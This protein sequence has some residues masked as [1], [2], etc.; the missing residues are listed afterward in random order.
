MLV[1]DIRYKIG[2]RSDGTSMYENFEFEGV[3]SSSTLYGKLITHSCRASDLMA[4]EQDSDSL[5]ERR[6]NVNMSSVKIETE[7]YK[8][9]N[10]K[11]KKKSVN[12]EFFCK[13]GALIR[14]AKSKCMK[15]YADGYTGL[16]LASGEF[17]A[18]SET[19]YTIPLDEG[20]I[21]GTVKL[22]LGEIMEMHLNTPDFIVDIYEDKGREMVVFSEIKNATP[23]GFKFDQETLGFYIAP[24]ITEK[25][26][27]KNGIYTSLE[28]IMK[29]NPD[30]EFDWLL[31]NK[32]KIVS[33]EDLQYV[34]DYIMSY[35]GYVYYD[36]ETT[37]LNITFKSRIGQAD[38]LVGVVLSVKYGESFYFPT[39]MKSIPNLCGGDHWY[40]MEHYMRPILEGKQLVAHNMSYDWKVSYIYD[41]NANIVHD[42]MA[43]FKLT[44]GAEKE[45][46]PMGLKELARQFL[47][48]DSLEL[49]DLIEADEWGESDIKFWDLPYESV[50]L[51]A[52]ADTDNTKGLL[53]YALSQEL[54]VKYNATR[55]YEIEIAFSFAVAYQEFYGHKV[56]VDNLE[57]LRSEITAGL[58]DN[59]NKLVD[60][61][62]Y[63]FNPNSPSQLVNIMYN[64]LGIPPQISRKTNRPTTDKETL[65]KLSEITD[66]EGNIKYPFC[67]I[68]QKYREFEGVRKILD[69]FPDLATEDGYLFSRVMQYGTTTGRVSIN[70][71]NYQSYN[72]PVKKHIVP[73][74][75]FYMTDSDYS[76]VEYRVLG[77]MSGNK[78]IMEG[79]VDPDFDYHA[80]QAARMYNVPYAAVTKTLRKAAKGINFGLPY[81]M[82]DESLG[83]RVFGE[84]SDENTRKAA[85]LR[86]KYFEGQE[87][88]QELFE[89]ARANGVNKGYTETYFGRRRYYHR[90][91]FSVNAIRRQAGNQVIQGCQDLNT[92]ILTKEF[93]IVKLGDILNTNVTVWDGDKWSNGDV[94]PAGNKRKTVIKFKG[95]QTMICS[96]NHKFLV[97]T[98]RGGTMWVEAQDLHTASTHRNPHRIVVNKCH[99]MSDYVYKSDR[100]Y[101]CYTSNANNI[102]LEDID[103]SYKIGIVLGRLASDGHQTLNHS[104]SNAIIQIVAEHEFNIL[105]KLRECMENLGYIE[106][107][108]DIR[109]DRNES[110]TNLSVYSTSL[111]K[112]VNDLDIRHK[113][114]KNIFMDTELLRGFLC[115]YFD[116]DGGI[117]GKTI[118][119]V[120]GKQDNFKTLVEDMQKAL[121]FFGIRSRI[122]EY[123]DRWILQIKTNDNELFLKEIGFLN[124]D[125]QLAGSK[126][127]CIEEEKTFGRCII[128]ESVE[129]TDELIPMADVCNTDGGYYVADG[130]VTHNTA[131]D[132]YKLAVGRLFKR[133][134]KEGWLGKV[135]L[136]GFIHDEVLCEVHN[137]IDPM[138]WLKVLREEFEVKIDGWCPLYMGFG[139]GMSWYEA[140]SVELPIKL[141]W[142]L[143][144]RYGEQGYPKWNGNG[145][146]LCAEVPDILR[147]FSIRDTA[148]QLLDE[149][150]QNNVIKPTLNNEM[151]DVL[152]EDKGYY[153]DV[154]NGW[155]TE[156]YQEAQGLSVQE[157][158]R[159]YKDDILNDLSM[160]HI[161]G[162]YMDGDN[163]CTSFDKTKDT[164]QAITDFCML[165]GVDRSKVNLLNIPDATESAVDSESTNVNYDYYDEDDES[166]FDKQ[167]AIDTRIDTLG[168]YLDVQEKMIM[169]KML[170]AEYMTF[171]KS[172]S[173]KGSGDYKIRF[174]DCSS[175]RWF[176]TDFY[177]MSEDINT[178][179]QL[180]IRYFNSLVAKR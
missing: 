40:F 143:V 85:A 160:C 175:M 37:G 154:I 66:I 166:V 142:E 15:K 134:C 108:H 71:P 90:N 98:K 162:L 25:V 2:L 12:Y 153:E 167:K 169:L 179:Q 29:N 147:D 100:K 89:T 81:G 111:S 30:R 79:F 9:N 75:G 124:I 95:G 4:G 155:L 97:A 119:C 31:D 50:R 74:P 110:I 28:D 156:S 148:S 126:L 34:C 60:I 105:P 137:S 115:G 62:G 145:S 163:I 93:G 1:G 13:L 14:Y 174:K 158:L 65:K 44:I 164:Q 104:G 76:S 63:E 11:N 86:E 33:D 18:E 68:L 120:F 22:Y 51:Y 177:I 133:I 3:D 7:I 161:T 10:G 67:S 83:I 78:M 88:I 127:H 173:Y 92:R 99:A 141:Q 46:F 61:V 41:I 91:K 178:I 170:P 125:K 102:Y 43:L 135:L 106:D 8:D 152:S 107:N 159:T 35:E 84:K 47:H 129:V 69:Q 130:I 94:L 5:W 52:C 138:T 132:I 53:D 150:N 38:Q 36:T 6:F 80:Y 116:G 157:F 172:K 56:D 48:R 16:K 131:A 123:D 146:E 165:H 64:E 87:D 23:K 128:P 109:E 121:L 59:M 149:N 180:Y 42:T 168:L 171:I 24:Q 118:T 82:G 176:D 72:N 151:F 54:L 101:D 57:T 139:F 77:S 114:H 70:S 27:T 39:Q 26:R 96:P 19:S 20:G 113:I 45:N 55:V 32:Y 73:R 49:S 144:E 21:L 58:E 17:V 136:T 103:D 140:K 112:E 122:R 117:S